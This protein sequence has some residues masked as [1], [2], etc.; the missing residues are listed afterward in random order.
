MKKFYLF[1][2][3]IWGCFISNKTFAQRQVPQEYRAA[4]NRIM[5]KSFSDMNMRWMRNMSLNRFYGSVEPQGYKFKVMM[6]DSTVKTIK[7]AILYDSVR[8]KTYITY[9][10][11]NPKDYQVRMIKVYANQ[12]ICIT[13]TD[14]DTDITGM[15]NDSCW[16]FKV[17]KGKISAYSPLSETEN[18]DSFHIRAFKLGDGPMQKLDSASLGSVLK[19]NEKAY[20]IFI[21]KDYYKAISKYN[22]AKENQ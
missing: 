1:F 15:A 6:K 19:S 4:Y 13:R 5:A 12:T 21:K 11:K 16:F 10:D 14:Y 17:V 9:K 22:S 7:S 3:L 20:K 8:H 2:I 18:I